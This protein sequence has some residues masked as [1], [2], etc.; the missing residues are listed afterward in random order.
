MSL[1]R[2]FAYLDPPC[3]SCGNNSRQAYITQPFVPEFNDPSTMFILNPLARPFVS[4]S[5]CTLQPDLYLLSLFFLPLV[6]AQACLSEDL[7][8][9]SNDHH[10]PYSCLATPAAI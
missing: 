4:F 7:L 1:R 5:H 10:T 9:G 6:V 3:S 2:Q 8:C